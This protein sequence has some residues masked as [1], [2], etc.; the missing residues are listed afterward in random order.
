VYLKNAIAIK[1][2]LLISIFDMTHDSH[3]KEDISFSSITSQA[4]MNMFF[5][6]NPFKNM[7]GEVKK[8]DDSTTKKQT[9]AQPKALDDIFNRFGDEN[10]VARAGNE[11]TREF[12]LQVE[13]FEIMTYDSKVAKLISKGP[14]VT[15]T[16]IVVWMQGKTFLEISKTLEPICSVAT[17]TIYSIALNLEKK[18]TL[19]PPGPVTYTKYS[20]LDSVLVAKLYKVGGL[21]AHLGYNRACVVSNWKHRLSFNSW[22]YDNTPSFERGSFL[23]QMISDQNETSSDPITLWDLRKLLEDIPESGHIIYYLKM[24]FPFLEKV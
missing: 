6:T 13:L 20:V 15:L 8:E 9:V 4:I 5:G 14:T 2:F 11:I 19:K 12:M 18:V 23:L 1:R 16:E 21:A 7:F 22:M 17:S 3:V 24:Y 10:G